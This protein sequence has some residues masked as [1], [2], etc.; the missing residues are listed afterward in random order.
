MAR[1][2]SMP[3]PEQLMA[4]PQCSRMKPITTEQAGILTK[5]R[6][7]HDEINRHNR[8]VWQR[9][10]NTQQSLVAEL[11]EALGDPDAPT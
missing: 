2:T 9:L 4:S 11:K 10:W 1:F 6:I 5:Y 3:L 8:A 7:N